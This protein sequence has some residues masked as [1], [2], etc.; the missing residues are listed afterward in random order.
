[1]AVEWLPEAVE[2]EMLAATLAAQDVG[3]ALAARL[4]HGAASKDPIAEPEPAASASLDGDLGDLRVELFL[5]DTS[6]LDELA[7]SRTRLY[8]WALLLLVL[9]LSSG[10]GWLVH[11]T[12]REAR[13]TRL[14]T[15]F[16]SSVSHELRT[17]LTSIRMF[18]DTLLLGRTRDEAE[19]REA[20]SI[21]GAESERLTRLVERILDFSRMEAGRRAYRIEPQSVSEMVQAAVGACRPQIENLGFQVTCEIPAD[22]PAVPAD[23]DALVEV[24]VNLLSNAI[25]YSPDHRRVEIAARRDGEAVAIAVRDFGIGIPRSEQKKIFDKFYRV[26]HPLTAAIGGSGLGLSLVRYIVSA[27]GGEIL[28][29]SAP[30]KGSTFTVRLPLSRGGT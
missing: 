23:R 3:T 14:K 13:L 7:R 11:I 5:A 24:L 27:H 19:R 26:D 22:L 10:I 28:V 18:V 9:A 20:L 29:D 25:K 21:I 12:V 15:D 2:E 8:L 16:V 1:V 17:P 30:G 4:V 6:A